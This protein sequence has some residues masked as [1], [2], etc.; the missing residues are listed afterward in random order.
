MFFSKGGKAQRDERRKFS[1]SLFWLMTRHEFSDIL[2]TRNA[3]YLERERDATAVCE[4]SIFS[5]SAEAL[6][7]EIARRAIPGATNCRVAAAALLRSRLVLPSRARSVFF[8][9]DQTDILQ[10]ERVRER[11]L[12]RVGI[13]WLDFTIFTRYMIPFG[14]IIARSVNYKMKCLC[15]FW[16]E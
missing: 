5:N 15:C 12:L 13:L 9:R 11:R 4:N 10:E 7:R 2:R 6:S 1:F 16:C 8:R 14:Y 3:E